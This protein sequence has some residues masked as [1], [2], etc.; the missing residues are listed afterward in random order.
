MKDPRKLQ[1]KLA[2][3]LR[4]SSLHIQFPF[5]RPWTDLELKSVAW[6]VEDFVNHNPEVINS[7]P[8]K[9]WVHEYYFY[10]TDIK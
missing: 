9:D 8:L 4:S 5:D 7:D 10:R 3:L 1:E 2:A 6:V